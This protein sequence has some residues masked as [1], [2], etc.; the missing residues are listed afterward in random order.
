M[1]LPGALCR[2]SRPTRRTNW[3]LAL[4]LNFNCEVCLLENTASDLAFYL[5]S[6]PQLGY[7]SMIH[8]QLRRTVT[9]IIS[10]HEY[11]D[12]LFL[13]TVEDHARTDL[14]GHYPFGKD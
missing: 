7:C 12:F 2:S 3:F 1:R 8:R 5:S 11:V 13:S 10:S 6:T 4:T 14:F 9:T